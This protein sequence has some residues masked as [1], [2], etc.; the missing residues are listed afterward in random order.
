MN[1][2]PL[3]PFKAKCG[4]RQGDPMSSLLFVIGMEYLS[5]ILKAAGEAK[6]FKFHPRYSKLKLNHLV[7]ADDLM[8]FCKG[9]TQSIQTLCQGVQLFSSSSGL[10]ANYT[11]LG[12]YLAGVNDNFRMH[13]ANTLDFTFESLP[14]K[15]LGMP[16]TS[17][18]YTTADCEYLVDKMTSRIRSCFAKNVSYTARL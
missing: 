9:D 6:D 7:F 8:L 5:R 10:E 12:I 18:R 3:E 15:Y 14:V 4:V 11:K 1:G 13:A 16:L 2:N 17:K